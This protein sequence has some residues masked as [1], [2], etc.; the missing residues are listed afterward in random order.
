MLDDLL[1]L[2]S[3]MQTGKHQKKDKVDG[4][5]VSTVL[6]G[7]MGWETAILDK[8]G[9]YPV[10]RYGSE[11]EATQGHKDWVEKAKTLT[12]VTELGYGSIL[13]S[14]QRTLVRE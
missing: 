3:G 8:N 4:L 12:E 1:R 2:M 10:Q 7:Y 11:K 6:S 13:D 5:V 14:Q 9:T